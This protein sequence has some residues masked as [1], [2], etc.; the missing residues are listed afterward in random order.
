MVSFK[1]KIGWI[2]LRK[3]ENKNCRSVSF[4]FDVL[5]K[6]SKK[7]Q[8]NQKNTIMASFQTKIGWKWMRNRENK[9]SNSISFRHDA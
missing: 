1:A 5:Q 3:R 9:N 2:M 8:K 4:L 7:I 6:I